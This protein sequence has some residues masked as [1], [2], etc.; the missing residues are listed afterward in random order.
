MSPVLLTL[1]KPQCLNSV[2]CQLERGRSMQQLFAKR[3]MVTMVWRDSR[4]S[5]KTHCRKRISI[6]TG[7]SECQGYSPASSINKLTELFTTYG[8]KSFVV[9]P[10][11]YLFLEGGREIVRANCVAVCYVRVRDSWGTFRRSCWMRKYHVNPKLTLNYNDNSLSVASV[12]KRTL[13]FFASSC[14]KKF[15]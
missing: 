9:L 8:G 1:P 13:C 14:A 4:G 10:F 3:S 15:Y 6:L 11:E 5:L 7:G 2:Q 12:S